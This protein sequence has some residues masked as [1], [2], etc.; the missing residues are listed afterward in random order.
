MA[1]HLPVLLCIATCCPTHSMIFCACTLL[2]GMEAKDK[3]TV[4]R[5]PFLRNVYLLIIVDDGLDGDLHY[6]S[7]ATIKSMCSS[8]Q[9]R[10]RV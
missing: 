6:G 9:G 4:E 3:E 8:R 5:P 1:T 2:G 7:W 10:R